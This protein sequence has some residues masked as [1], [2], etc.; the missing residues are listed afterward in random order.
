MSVWG[1][2][3]ER[4]EVQPGEEPPPRKL[5]ALDGGGI[6]GILTLEVLLKIE[7][8][9]AEA[10]GEGE[11][12]RLCDFSTTSEER[13]REPLSPRVWLAGCRPANCWTSTSKQAQRCSTRRSSF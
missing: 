3:A 8:L 13:A 11:K 6:R 9:L 12:F 4:Y 7:R 10:T 5:L 1:A 2:L